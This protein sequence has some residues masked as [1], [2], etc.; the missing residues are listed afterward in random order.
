MLHHD[1]TKSLNSFTHIVGLTPLRVGED[2][3][4]FDH[5]FEFLFVSPLLFELNH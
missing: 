1:G 3:I 5:K 2:S 4:S